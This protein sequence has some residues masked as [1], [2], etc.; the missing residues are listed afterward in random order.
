[1]LASLPR[2]RKA[3]DRRTTNWHVIRECRGIVQADILA[4][5]V[6]HVDEA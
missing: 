5:A 1:M 6:H 4:V 3:I 2:P